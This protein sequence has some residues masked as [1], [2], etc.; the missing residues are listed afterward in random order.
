MVGVDIAKEIKV[1]TLVYSGY[2]DVAMSE[3]YISCEAWTCQSASN[4]EII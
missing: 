3:A 4:L 2:R 1:Q